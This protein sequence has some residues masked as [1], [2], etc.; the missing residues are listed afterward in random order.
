MYVESISRKKIARNVLK[1]MEHY[2]Q[3]TEENDNWE[4]EI[5]NRQWNEIPGQKY[6]NIIGT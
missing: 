2:P 6:E 5:G 3:I 1:G 4:W